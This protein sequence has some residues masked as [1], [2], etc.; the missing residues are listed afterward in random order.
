MA[1]DIWEALLQQRPGQALTSSTYGPVG[2]L[3]AAGLFWAFGPDLR[4]LPLAQLLCLPVYGLAL[5][6]LGRR[7]YGPGAGFLA[8]LYLFTTPLFSRLSTAYL[9][10]IQSQAL[11]LTGLA[12]LICGK[13]L[14]NRRGAILFGATLGL[15]A[16]TKQEVLVL[17]LLPLAWYVAGVLKTVQTPEARRSMFRHLLLAGAVATL[18][19]LPFLLMV[20]PQSVLEGRLYALTCA[21]QDPEF[22][23]RPWT[24]LHFMTF[25]SLGAGHMLLLVLGLLFQGSG[26]LQRRLVTS[27]LLWSFLLI[28][29]GTANR[30]YY[31]LN[32]MGCAALVATGWAFSSRMPRKTPILV[33]L[34]VLVYGIPALAGWMIPAQHP[35]ISV[36]RNQFLRLENWDGWKTFAP[37]LAN[38]PEQDR[39]DAV[40][41]LQD[42]HREFPA[43]VLGSARSLLV[44]S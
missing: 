6:A 37:I 40:R 25:K 4:L 14:E 31:L 5:T 30:E 44:A 8:C 38:R 12:L 9:L 7:L 21:M 36:F 41:L 10:E 24:W 3:P 15:M 27:M 28:H 33:T 35:S 39:E 16:M 23:W 20:G 11:V 29:L 42:L 19:C 22:G 17:W 26:S 43:S 2:Y 13:A 18:L 1:F 32:L 34:V